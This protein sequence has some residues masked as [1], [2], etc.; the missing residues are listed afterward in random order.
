MRLLRS[1]V[2]PAVAALTGCGIE[3]LAQSWQLDRLRVLAVR[4][5][6]AEPRPG[7][8]VTIDSL[9]YVPPETTLSGTLYQACLDFSDFG[10]AVDDSVIDQL[11]ALDPTTAT[12]EQL[13]EA[14][15]LLQEA[16]VIGFEPGWAPTWTPPADALD[17]LTDAERAEGLNAV[18]NIM[19]FAGE[20]FD[21]AELAFKRV[22]VSEAT[23]PN[24]NPTLTSLTI[25]EEITTG[26][27]SATA[28]QAY[29]LAPLLSDDSVETYTYITEA[30][31]T[32]ER[33]EEPYITW[34]AEGGTF[35]QPY[36]LYPET[37]AEWTAP[38]ETFSGVIVAV[39]RD[40][41]GGM[42]WTSI[43]MEVP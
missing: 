31:V 13:A 15:E 24:H 18:I 26:S 39:V 7:E 27:F 9:L 30:G 40:R 3:D 29:E 23:T 8:L 25:D 2:L 19:A 1:L 36:S 34:Y 38:K 10:C 42:G 37:T 11:S 12:P 20:S 35:D 33:I 14:I 4:A 5:T 28:G 41:R 21:D 22:P 16:G 32:E 6:P 43:R 17:G